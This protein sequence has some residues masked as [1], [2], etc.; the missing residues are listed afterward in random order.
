M[1][2]NAASPFFLGRCDICCC[3]VTLQLRQHTAYR[4][5]GDNCTSG[6]ANVR[7]LLVL[8]LVCLLLC[9]MM[10]LNEACRRRRNGGGNGGGGLPKKKF[11]GYLK[12]VGRLLN[13]ANLELKCDDDDDDDD[14]GDDDNEGDHYYDYEDEDNDILLLLLIVIIIL[15]FTL[16]TAGHVD[17]HSTFTNL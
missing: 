5:I 6:M 17:T 14:D 1:V 9:Q 15:M 8:S 4:Y 13:S 10:P 12:I 2:C 3:I 16:I 11:F 7:R